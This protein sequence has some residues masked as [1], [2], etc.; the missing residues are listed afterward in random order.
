M[1]FGGHETFPIRDGWL[2]KGLRLLMVDREKLHDEYVA[3]WLGVGGNMAKSIRHWLVATK[4]AEPETGK[5]LGKTTPLRP[6]DFGEL[7]WKDDR[8]FTAPGTWWAIHI[9]LVNNPEYAASW[10]WFFNGFHHDRF[11]R[12]LCVESLRRHL[13]LGSKRKP[14]PRTIERDLGCL[15]ACYARTIPQERVDPEDVKSCPMVELGLLNHFKSSGYYQLVQD[16]KPIAPEILGYSLAIAFSDDLSKGSK[17]DIP[18]LDMIRRNG[19]PGRCFVLNS[20]ALFETALHA[21]SDGEAG[22]LAVVGLAGNRMIRVRKRPALDWL[23]Q[24]YKVLQKR[25]RHAA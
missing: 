2:H 10:S 25:D 1:R 4:L 5:A 16:R 15:L 6:T 24:Y 11:E 7:V 21:E 18:L 13:E 3:D 22:D 12:S 23:T 8:Y 19:G 17:A 14:S 9:H 20:E